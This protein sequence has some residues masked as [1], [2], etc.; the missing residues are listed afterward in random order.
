MAMVRQKFGIVFSV[1]PG[2]DPRWILMDPGHFEWIQHVW[3]SKNHWILCPGFPVFIIL[4]MHKD[5]LRT[6]LRSLRVP[7]SR[8]PV[9][10]TLQPT[11]FACGE[12]AALAYSRHVCGARGV[13]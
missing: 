12:S 7:A 9:S 10:R 5:M 6:V 11:R 4:R 3:D 13:G 1:D 8:D 2:V